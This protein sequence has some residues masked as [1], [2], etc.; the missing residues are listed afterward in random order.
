MQPHS[1]AALALAGHLWNSYV[2]P[3]IAKCVMRV[4]FRKHGEYVSNMYDMLDITESSDRRELKVRIMRSGGG[5]S[6]TV[7]I[8]RNSLEEGSEVTMTH[9]TIHVSG[10]REVFNLYKMKIVSGRHYNSMKYRNFAGDFVS[11]DRKVL[12]FV[13]EVKD[14]RGNFY[15]VPYRLDR[16][17]LIHS[18]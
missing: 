11:D 15:A 16:I 18:N 5:L 8:R 3:K 12:N 10:L 13:C 7:V 1:M 6:C 4:E 14:S 17:Q 9:E 2:P